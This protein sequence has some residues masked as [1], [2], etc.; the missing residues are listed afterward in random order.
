MKKTMFALMLLAIISGALFAQTP[1]NFFSAGIG[2]VDHNFLVSTKTETSTGSV[3]KEWK[4]NHATNG[5]G[6]FGFFDAKYAELD[7]GVLFYD[8]FPIN[9]GYSGESTNL[10]IGLIGKYPFD[11]GS[12][13][14]L[15]PLF[16]ISYSICLDA[17]FATFDST[18]QKM[19][20]KSNSDYKS[21]WDVGKSDEDKW[22]ELFDYNQFGFKLGFGVDYEIIPKL[23]IRGEAVYNLGLL[24]NAQ[25]W[26][27][28]RYEKSYKSDGANSVT[29]NTFSHGAEVKLAVGYKF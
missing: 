12:K 15:F 20:T 18:T 13:G 1:S 19:V 14:K 5:I 29:L 26:N 11:L 21:E 16:G 9:Y 10:T 3:T 4:E 24:S 2:F 8:D 25:I 17:R 6:V 28:K 23:Y 7:L 27:N 22:P